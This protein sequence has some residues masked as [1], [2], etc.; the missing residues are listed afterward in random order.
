M[1]KKAFHFT[2]RLSPEEWRKLERLAQ[3][4]EKSAAAVLRGLLAKVTL[5][6]DAT[7]HNQQEEQ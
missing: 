4:Q 3:Q 1:Q 6:E 2:F 5:G 7:L